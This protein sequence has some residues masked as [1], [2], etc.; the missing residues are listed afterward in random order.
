MAGR[1]TR[2]RAAKEPLPPPLP[3]ET[4][5][6]G[7]LVAEALRLYGRRFWPSL[8]LGLAP[9]VVD[10]GAAELSRGAAFAFV[11]LVGGPLLTAAYLGAVRLAAAGPLEPRSLVVAFALGVLVFAPFPF[12][13]TAFVLPGLAWLALVGLSVPAAALE[14]LPFRRALGR[15][16]AL[17]RA[18]YV[19]ALGSL[20][21]LAITY[22]LARLPLQ[23]LLRDQADNTLRVAAFLSDVV[24]SPMLFLGAALL[25][26]DQD[27]RARLPRGD[28]GARIAKR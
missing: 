18:D 21:T 24:V 4:R 17:A 22:F 23:F 13:V 9:A 12:L 20:A 15:G 6:V 14:R 11:V 2:A 28:G 10:V 26:Y 7:Q 1:P 5:T 25:Y 19:H 8:A 16:V 27:A 3:P